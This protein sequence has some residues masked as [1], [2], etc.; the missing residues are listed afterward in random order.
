M[1]GGKK[2]FCFF[3]KRKSCFVFPVWIISS[4]RK[5]KVQFV[6]VDTSALIK[7]FSGL[8][9]LIREPP[10]GRVE[11]EKRENPGRPPVFPHWN[12]SLGESDLGSAS[13]IPASPRCRWHRW[14]CLT[15]GRG[16]LRLS[17]SRATSCPGGWLEA[18]G[19]L[20]KLRREEKLLSF[21]IESDKVVGL[22]L[23]SSNLS[24][25]PFTC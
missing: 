13:L 7:E 9:R 25:K 12:R 15:W 21:K 16:S 23:N 14:A 8:M 3:F 10:F 22:I 1:K 6:K 17:K 18:E 24:D 20:W 11:Q 2:K 19:R 5:T 4:S